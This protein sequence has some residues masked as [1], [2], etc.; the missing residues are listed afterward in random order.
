MT[1]P[2]IVRQVKRRLTARRKEAG[3]RAKLAWEAFVAGNRYFGPAEREWTRLATA[4]KAAVES[5]E[6]AQ[7]C[8]TTTELLNCGDAAVREAT[9]LATAPPAPKRKR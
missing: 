9:L 5:V 4:E 6:A 1:D 7:P 2:E 3:R 8:K